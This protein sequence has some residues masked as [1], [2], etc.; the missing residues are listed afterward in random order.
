LWRGHIAS[1]PVAQFPNIVPPEN[2]A[3]S[4]LCPGGRTGLEQS[5]ATRSNSKS[6]GVDNMNYMYS[7]NATANSQTTMVMNF[8]LK[9]DPNTDLILAQSRQQLAAASFRPKLALTGHDQE[10]VPAP[11]MLVAC[12]SPK[13]TFDTKFLGNYAYI[14][15]TIRLPACTVWARRRF[16]SRAVCD[17]ALGASPTNSRRWH[18]GYGHRQCSAGAEQS[19]SAVRSAVNLLSRTNNSPI[20]CL[21]KAACRPRSNSK[22]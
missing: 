12:V 17:E 1:L 10:S 4:F 15:L 19:Q 20:P 5:V 7:L 2:S 16:S 8:D 3:A 21:R 11:L 9:T 13:G 18:H 6:N 14:N 22:T